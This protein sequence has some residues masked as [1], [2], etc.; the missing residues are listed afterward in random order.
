MKKIIT[1]LG[2]I[3]LIACQNKE[4][5]FIIEDGLLIAQATVLSPNNDGSIARFVGYVLT[6]KDRIVYAGT[7]KPE[8]KG[9]FANI[10]GKGKYIM[11]GLIDSHVHLANVAG[12]TWKH[13]KKY[14]ELT[15]AYFSQLPKSFL[16]YGYTTLIDVNNYAPEVIAKIQNRPLRPDI[17]TCGNQVQVMDDFMME[18]E[19]Y[20]VDER[21]QSP[22]LYD[23]Y[24]EHVRI[25]DSIDLE[26]HTPNA[27][28]AQIAGKQH[29][30]CVKTL[31]EDESS[32]FPLSWE[33]PT[34][35]IM[36]DLVREAHME[37][38]PV[39]MHAPSF[40]GQQFGLEAG[41]DIF[42]HSMW[43]WYE[44]PEQFLDT[45]FTEAHRELLVRIAENGIGYQ[46]T[47][48]SI[49]GEVDLMEGDFINGPALE[50]VYPMAYLNWL[51]T[52]EG[53]W[54]KQKILQRAKIVEAINP[55][56]YYLLR[57]KFETDEEMFKGIQ[58]VL[59]GRMDAVVKFLADHRANLLF[60][61]DGVAMNMSTNPP[62]YNGYLEMQHWVNAG[63][64][65][66]QLFFAATYNNAKAF[67]LLEEY[68]SIEAGKMANLLLLNKDPLVAV[69]AYDAIDHIIIQG[70]ALARSALS[71]EGL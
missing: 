17:Y 5:D 50:Q 61:T 21:L 58:D 46:P 31:F 14:P 71:A 34:I 48:R 41:V 2:F 53:Q 52:D 47:F 1:L 20:P 42:S 60:A 37:G 70:Q 8:V 16:Y 54:G 23:R 3:T 69:M 36:K 33:L 57:S 9:N 6:D 59:K 10:D 29:A 24:N 49:H 38:L 19:G 32:G 39:L 66:S 65:L 12:A 15:E 68:G 44:N 63:V 64:P 35:E 30:I 4:G 67:H 27:I 40:S 43:N 18:M 28:I 45:T 7:D 26:A 25:P 55:E 13:Q 11:P 51:K 56:L 22:F 62:G